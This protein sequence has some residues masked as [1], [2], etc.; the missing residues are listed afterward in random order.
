[1][2]VRYLKNIGTIT[3]SQQRTLYEKKVL[4]AGCG[5]LGGYVIEFLTR[6]GIGHLVVC[7]GDYFEESN[8]NRQLYATENTLGMHKAEAAK[9]RIESVNRSGQV[10]K[11][12]QPLTTK[13]M[14]AALHGC[15]LAI[16][17]LDNL[18]SRFLLE[19]TCEQLGIPY[20]YGGV[21]GWFGSVGTVMPRMRMIQKLYTGV[22]KTHIASTIAMTVAVTASVQAVE[23]VKVLTGEGSLI[24]K[25]LM[26]D[27][28]NYKFDII[29]VE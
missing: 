4:V 19:Q 7:D 20:I 25:L 1:M 22:P 16:D 15:D 28:Q 17:A 8:L 23:A 2:D 27:L 21:N 13:N 18:E 11:I 3:E 24:N 10:T 26:M 9:D 5:G 29:E 12:C 6:L 14:S